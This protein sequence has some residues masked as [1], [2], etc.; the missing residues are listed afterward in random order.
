MRIFLISHAIFNNVYYSSHIINPSWVAL[1]DSRGIE[2]RP[3]LAFM[4]VTVILTMMILY[5][6]AIILMMNLVI[7]KNDLLYDKFLIMVAALL[8]PGLIFVDNAHFQ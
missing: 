1:H 4:R 6:P 8:Y 2:S 7:P 3:H 5:A